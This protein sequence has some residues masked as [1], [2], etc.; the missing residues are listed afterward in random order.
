MNKYLFFFKQH[1]KYYINKT[2]VLVKE[3]KSKNITLTFTKLSQI[4]KTFPT[5]LSTITLIATIKLRKWPSLRFLPHDH[6]QDVT[7]RVGS[8]SDAGNRTQPQSIR[9]FSPFFSNFS[10]FCFSLL[11]S[12]IQRECE[13]EEWKYKKLVYASSFPCADRRKTWASNS[14]ECDSFSQ[15][16][17]VTFILG[18][19]RLNHC[20]SLV[21][22][23]AHCVIEKHL[24]T[25]VNHWGK[26]GRERRKTN[27]SW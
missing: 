3:R 24:V 14:G 25:C 22:P 26:R 19:P 7:A 12:S 23:E 6:P 16:L 27:H 18:I 15:L 2:N 13:T 10:H 17:F 21:I 1:S 11:L 20:A 8:K 5:E 9:I 4:P